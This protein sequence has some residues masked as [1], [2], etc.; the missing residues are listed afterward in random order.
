MPSSA[1]RPHPIQLATVS[2]TPPPL[3]SSKPAGQQTIM[4][5]SNTCGPPPEDPRDGHARCRLRLTLP[6]VA[7]RVAFHLG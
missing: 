5:L 2:P 1:T 3:P 6:D 4:R 7:S